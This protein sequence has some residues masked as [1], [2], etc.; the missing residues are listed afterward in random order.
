MPEHRPPGPRPDPMPIPVRKTYVPPATR[1]TQR[2]RPRLPD[3]ETIRQQIARGEH[4]WP[5]EHLWPDGEWW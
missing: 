1:R 5:D 3:N 4:F 2:P